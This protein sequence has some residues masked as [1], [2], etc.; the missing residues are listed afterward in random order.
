MT[1]DDRRPKARHTPAQVQKAKE[2][3]DLC[4]GI[5]EAKALLDTLAGLERNFKAI[6]SILRKKEP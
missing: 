1:D 4:G 2:L 6:K 3:A 5:T